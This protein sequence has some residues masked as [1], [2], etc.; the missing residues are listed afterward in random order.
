MRL[1][2]IIA[3]AAL[4]A[5]ILTQGENYLFAQSP[6]YASAGAFVSYTSLGGFVPFFGGVYGDVRYTVVQ[7]FSNNTMQV[8]LNENI[9]QGELGQ[10][11]NTTFSRYYLDNV[12]SP[13][14]FPAVPLSEL[15]QPQ[16][17]IQGIL[18]NLSERGR[19]DV[20]AGTFQTYEYVGKDSNGTIT[21]YWFDT[22]TG[23]VV[24]MSSGVSAMQLTNS[25]IAFPSSTQNS[26]SSIPYI[27]VVLLTW[28]A[29]TLLFLAIRRHYTSKSS[30]I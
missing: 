25:N 5:I 3:L 23:V 19:V 12:N 17:T 27:E 7:V 24:E 13:N 6:P 10:E 18:C 30:N 21:H 20:P 8:L 28:A 16:L 26:N 29:M 4:F 11:S 14:V 1:S 9:S 22:N 15:G 2:S